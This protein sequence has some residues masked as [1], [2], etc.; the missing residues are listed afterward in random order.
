MMAISVKE[1]TTKVKIKVPQVIV[2]DWD[3]V[4][5]FAKHHV[6]RTEC[7]VQV[8]SGYEGARSLT[9]NSITG[10]QWRTIISELAKKRYPNNESARYDDALRLSSEFLNLCLLKLKEVYQRQGKNVLADWG[11]QALNQLSD[12]G[13]KVHICSGTILEEIQTEVALTKMDSK[14]ST[15]WGYPVRKTDLLYS[16]MS[17]L[18]CEAENICLVDDAPQ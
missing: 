9:Y 2:F 18:Q 14:V 15:I 11:I 8:I 10:S 1:Q 16:L 12:S 17:E 7:L 5:S 4:F 3:D 13:T 6:N